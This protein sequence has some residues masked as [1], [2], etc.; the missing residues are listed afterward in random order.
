MMEQGRLIASLVYLASIVA[1]L[2]VAFQVGAG[3]SGSPAQA[4]RW[5][6]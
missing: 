3:P 1:T 6:R 5:R 4:S 2:V